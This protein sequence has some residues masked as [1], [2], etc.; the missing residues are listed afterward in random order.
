MWDDLKNLGVENPKR[1]CRL[2]GE[3]I[4]KFP[5]A[6]NLAVEKLVKAAEKARQEET[7]STL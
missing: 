7:D 6:M 2:L 3:A 4:E 5:A 1:F